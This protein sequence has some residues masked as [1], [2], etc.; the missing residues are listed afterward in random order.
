MTAATRTPTENTT[1]IAS[2]GAS[3]LSQTKERGRATEV[4]RALMNIL[5]DLDVKNAKFEAVNAELRAE[6]AE[7][8]RSERILQ[9]QSD[10]LA[11]SNADL[12]QFAY[13]ASHDLSEPLRAISGPITLLARRYEGQLDADADEYIGFAVDGCLRMQAIIDGLL[14]YSRVGR[15]EGTLESVDCNALLETVLGWL[16]PA[17]EASGANVRVGELPVILADKTQLGQVF[18]N[19]L[20]NAVKF[21]APGTSPHIAVGAVQAGAAWRFEVTDNGIGIDPEYRKRIFGIFKRLHGREEYPGTGI[22]LSLVKKIVERH[23]G[24]VGVADAPL[25]GSLFWFTLAAD[26]GTQ[27]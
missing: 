11:R 13:V 17:I 16:A 24:T 20:S 19:L 3:S 2:P 15:L 9:Q 6:V 27:S 22:G 4:R 25:G 18:L 14:A 12:E 10:D 26:G 21:V 1:P 8:T 23:G 7:R 5:D